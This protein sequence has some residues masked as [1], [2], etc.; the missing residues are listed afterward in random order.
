MSSDSSD[1]KGNAQ[2]TA[3]EGRKLDPF[4][5]IDTPDAEDNY[6]GHLGSTRN[7]NN[8]MDRM[9]KTQELRV[10]IL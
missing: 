4:D 8:D 3:T 6:H 9:G 1:V 2:S 7:D 10:S 5:R